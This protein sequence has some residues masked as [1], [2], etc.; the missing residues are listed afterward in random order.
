MAVPKKKTSG[1][2]EPAPGAPRDHRPGS[3]GLPQLRPARTAQGLP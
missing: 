1:A 2:Q 3:R